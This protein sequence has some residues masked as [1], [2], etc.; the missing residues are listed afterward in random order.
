MRRL[1]AFLALVFPLAVSAA[2]AAHAELKD[3]QG[4]TVGQ[5][6]FEETTEGVRVVL[7]AKNLPPGPHG[8]HVHETGKCDAPDF[9]TAGAHFNPGKK[10]HG[11][12]NPKGPHAGDLPNLEVSADGTGRASA[13]A[14]GATLGQGPTSLLKDGGTALVVHAK[15]DDGKTDPA[16]NAGAR[17]ACGIVTRGATP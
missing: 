4:R 5:A 10:Q 6:M 1:I 11:H 3:A 15:P 9:K 2:P 8:F 12:Q 17:I 14:A 16:G 7:D 13:V